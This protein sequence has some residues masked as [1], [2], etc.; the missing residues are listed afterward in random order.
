MNRRQAVIDEAMTWLGT[1]W[2]HAAAVKGA[3]IDCAHFLLEVHA[4]CGLIERFTPEYYPQDFALHSPDERFLRV[5]ERFTTPVAV[6]GPGDVA[7]WK[8]GRCFSH[9][10]I[11]IEWPR[12]IH[13]LRGEGV[14]L[15]SA[16]NPELINRK[17]R[18]FTL[19]DANGG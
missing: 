16:E 3:G 18:F 6:P 8:F 15:D 9:A 2:I 17:V 14:V 4:E 7:V 1:P 12:I 19:G 5:V 11:I 10:A 13:A